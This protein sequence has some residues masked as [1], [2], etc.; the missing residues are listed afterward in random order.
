MG[1]LSVM[2]AAGGRV[3]G[4]CAGRPQDHT[5]TP[6]QPLTRDAGGGWERIGSG[7]VFPCRITGEGTQTRV[8]S[9]LSRARTGGHDSSICLAC[10]GLAR[11][12]K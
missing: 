4:Q 12:D 6:A 8:S 7:S 2:H 5:V 10:R 1:K 9:Y 3:A 11:L